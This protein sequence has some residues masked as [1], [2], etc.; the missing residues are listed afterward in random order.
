M[1]RSPRVG[2]ELKK[3]AG[4]VTPARRRRPNQ[5]RRSGPFGGGSCGYDARRND[6]RL[7]IPKALPRRLAESWRG[8]YGSPWSFTTLAEETYEALMSDD[9]EAFA[10]IRVGSQAIT[11]AGRNVLNVVWARIK[12]GD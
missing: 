5:S 4:Q 10:R 1:C 3:K 2:V 9:P 8:A 12:R 6:R 11:R 7:K